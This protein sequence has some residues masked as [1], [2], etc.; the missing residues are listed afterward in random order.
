MANEPLV[1][2]VEDQAEVAEMYRLKLQFDGYRVAIAS[3]GLVG[4]QMVGSLLPDV[5]LLDMHLPGVS[6]LKV[7]A[8]LRAQ[9]ATQ[10]LPVL[11]LSADDSPSMVREAQRLQVSEYLIKGDVLP[12]H[13]SRA[14]ADVLATMSASA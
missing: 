7:L 6:G 8:A 5:V 1:L 9:E 2:L 4:L 11:M 10:K 12:S 14:V 3:D 13:L